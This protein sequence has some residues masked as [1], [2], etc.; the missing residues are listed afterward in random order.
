MDSKLNTCKL[1]SMQGN[2]HFQALISLKLLNLIDLE[3]V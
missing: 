3:G 2:A 1:S